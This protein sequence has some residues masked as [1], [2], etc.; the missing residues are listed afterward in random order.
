MKQL[1]EIQQFK[2]TKTQKNTLNV[3]GNKY[4]LNVSLFI[5][6]AIDEK[7]K[8]EKD[9]IFKHYKE[10]QEYLKNDLPF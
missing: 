7:L 4:N 3:L 5:R 9:S 2:I 8:R 10:V 1:T 6:N